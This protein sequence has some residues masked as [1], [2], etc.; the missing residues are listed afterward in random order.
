VTIDYTVP[1]RCALL[2]CFD[3]MHIPH[4]FSHHLRSNMCER[5]NNCTYS[6]STSRNFTSVPNS[7]PTVSSYYREPFPRSRHSLVLFEAY[8]MIQLQLTGR[9]LLLHRAI[10]KMFFKLFFL[11]AASV[12]VAV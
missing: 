5:D 7:T 2:Y 10:R 11:H 8:F 4:A 1:T 3:R 6:S 12:D 9:K